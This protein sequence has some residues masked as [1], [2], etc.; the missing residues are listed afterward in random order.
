MQ[1]FISSIL[2]STFLACTIAAPKATDNALPATSQSY[3]VAQH[4]ETAYFASGCFWCVEAVFEQVNGVED[5]ISGYAGGDTVNPT[6]NQVVTGRTGH[7]ETTKVIYDP[8]KIDFKTLVTVFFGS[9]DPTTLNRQGPDKGTHYRSIAFYQN[10]AEKLIIKKHIEKLTNTKRYINPIV[11]EV[12]AYEVFY[13]AEDYHQNYEQNNPNNP[14]IKAV[15]KPRVSS[16]LQAYPE[17]LKK[18]LE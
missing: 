15:S 11:T 1:L 17:L 16:F 10:D 7:A 12:K 2:S 13:Q 3:N 4:L 5:V 6:Y 14:Y 18:G 8:K 9:H